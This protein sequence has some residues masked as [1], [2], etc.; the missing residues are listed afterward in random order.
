MQF[1]ASAKSK[2]EESTVEEEMKQQ[3][4]IAIMKDLM[5]KIRSEGTMDA[6][7]RW[8]VAEL[9]AKDCD[10]AWTHTRWEDTMQKWYEW[11]VNMKKKDEKEKWR[12]CTSERWRRWLR[13]QKGVLDFSTKSRSQRCG[14]EECRF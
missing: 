7:N 5:K 13:V 8:W 2:Q 10:K 12:R 3:Q 6:K 9:L 1:A 4:R 11:L 14:E